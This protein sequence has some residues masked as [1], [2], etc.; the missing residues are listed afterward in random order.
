[1]GIISF[2]QTK[3]LILIFLVTKKMFYTPKDAFWC[4]QVMYIS[5]RPIRPKHISV[6]N[7][8][9]VFHVT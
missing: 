4:Q 3:P 7:I 6:E 5:E 9:H 2:I 8:E 1:M